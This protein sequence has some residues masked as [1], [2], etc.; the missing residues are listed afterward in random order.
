MPN[1]LL[2]LGGI[3]SKT[4]YAVAVSQSLQFANGAA[5]ENYNAAHW[6]GGDY[7][8]L[9]TAAGGPGTIYSLVFP[10]LPAGQYD[11]FIYLQAGG[12]P[13]TSDTI[14]EGW[15]VTWDGT[16]ITSVVS[17][18]TAPATA[19]SIAAALAALG[20]I[21]FAIVAP[22]LQNT[23]MT[24]VAG[25]DYLNADNRAITFNASAGI[26]PNLSGATL[27]LTS[28]MLPSNTSTG[29]ATWT[30]TGTVVT[31]G[32]GAQSLYV[33]IPRATTTGLAPANAG[34]DYAVVA[35]LASSGDV[36]TL[37]MGVVTVK[38]QS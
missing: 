12:S 1:N 33:E 10:A 25:D 8:N 5:L 34:Y 20:T 2:T 13:A 15:L 26:W 22:I 16:N 37:A 29:S 4:Y 35:T 3:A 7:C 24:I 21:N 31:S 27:Q 6:I 28:K 11:V 36:V 32:T 19:A 9:F 17:S 30:A 18:Y 23:T 38:K 14:A